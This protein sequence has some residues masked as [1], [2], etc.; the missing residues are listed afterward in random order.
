MKTAGQTHQGYRREN[1]E[2]NY[3]IQQFTDGS[4]LFA[5]ADGMG[6][7]IGGDMASGLAVEALNGCKRPSGNINSYLIELIRNAH[8]LVQKKVRDQPEYQGMGSTMVLAYVRKRLL[9]W[10]HVGDSRLYLFR[11]GNLMRITQDHT[12]PGQLLAEGEITEEEAEKHHMRNLL[13]KCVG[14]RE[15]DPDAGTFMMKPGD[16]LLLCSDGLYG[17]VPGSAI[18]QI[19]GAGDNLEEQL[20]ALID[21]ALE[22]GGSD[23]ITVVGA[24]V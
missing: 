10:A 13:L 8:D 4:C 7:E 5:V 1:N 3:Y 18:A 6:G 19:L 20:K 16:I 22:A 23:N 11:E 17:D 9:Y 14:C 21:A 2:D 12:I 24:K 15:C